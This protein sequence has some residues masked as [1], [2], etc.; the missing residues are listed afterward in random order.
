M[1]KN[2]QMPDS[3]KQSQIK[4]EGQEENEIDYDD[5][6]EQVEPDEGIS[7]DFI[8]IINNI[9]KDQNDIKTDQCKIIDR[10]VELQDQIEFLEI[11]FQ[12]KIQ[13]N[14]EIGQL[15][16]ELEMRKKSIL[17]IFEIDD[18]SMH[19]FKQHNKNKFKDLQEAINFFQFL[20]SKSIIYKDWHTFHC[21]QCMQFITKNQNTIQQ[22]IKNYFNLEQQI[23][24]I[25]SCI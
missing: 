8:Q 10:N 6:F 16:K 2:N 13:S 7:Q 22:Q 4:I 24:D 5:S 23:S 1:E 3:I 20:Q 25:K 12:K 9:R 14:R 21:S 15:E 18:F 11:T 17:D 19:M